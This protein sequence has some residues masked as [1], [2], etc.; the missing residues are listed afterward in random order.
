MS[1]WAL[2]SINLFPVSKT[3]IYYKLFVAR[4]WVF[5]VENLRL[6]VLKLVLENSLEKT[7][8]R[9]PHLPEFLIH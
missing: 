1:R 4:V 6:V 7:Q 8:T 5:R 3:S 2:L 9:R